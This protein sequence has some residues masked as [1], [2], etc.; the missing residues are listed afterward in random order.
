MYNLLIADDEHEI[1]QA[2][3]SYFPWQEIG[4]RVIG[5]VEN[6]REALK[7]IQKQEVDVILCDIKMPVMTGIKLAEIIFTQNIKTK[8]VFL[9]AYKD[10]DYAKKAL[11]YG[12]E[13]YIVKP[14]KYQELVEVFK[15]IKARLDQEK[16]QYNKENGKLELNDFS[17]KENI[18]NSKQNFNDK[19]V[20]TVKTLINKNLQTI[21][22]DDV[23]AKVHLS[24]CYLSRF[25]KEVTGEN[26]SDYVLKVKIKKAKELLMNIDYR[27]C[28]V[29]ERLG[30]SNPKNFARAFK[31]YTGMTP[32]QFRKGI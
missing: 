19:I 32:S 27:I 17:D 30:Y 5:V 26:F 20:L 12:V 2:I 31:S 25:F 13:D 24:S 1:R 23:A 16:N 15:K 7:L 11:A 14:T 6:G 22:L 21:T 3:S 18:E 4:Y 8:V 28:D 10:F 29:S 9:S